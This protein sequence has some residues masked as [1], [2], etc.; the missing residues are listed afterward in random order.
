MDFAT[1][2]KIVRYYAGMKPAS[3]LSEGTSTCLCLHA[4]ETR[5]LEGWVSEVEN[6]VGDQ[7][8]GSRLP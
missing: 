1:E 7:E 3:H 2:R 4:Y 8:I 5:N 6:E